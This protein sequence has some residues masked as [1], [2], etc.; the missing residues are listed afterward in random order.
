MRFLTGRGHRVLSRRF[1]IRH[2]EVDIISRS[3]DH[4]YFIEVKTRRPASGDFGGALGSITA[5][6]QRRMHRVADVFVAQEQLYDLVPHVALLT[7]E[8]TE[9][10]H[11]VHFLPDSFDV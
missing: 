3:G 5:L 8:P 1:R 10:G 6:K 2:G 9:T 4:L 7:V 11:H